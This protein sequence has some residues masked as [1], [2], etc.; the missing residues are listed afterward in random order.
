MI[1]HLCCV[2]MLRLETDILAFTV[3]YCFSEVAF[4]RDIK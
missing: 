3:F 2:V 4:E 1:H